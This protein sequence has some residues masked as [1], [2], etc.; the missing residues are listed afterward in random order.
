MKCKKCGVDIS[1]LEILKREEAICEDCSW[2]EIVREWALW[3]LLGE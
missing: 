3:E 2:E 1:V